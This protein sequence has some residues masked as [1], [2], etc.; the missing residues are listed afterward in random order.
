MVFSAVQNLE[1]RLELLESKLGDARKDESGA[2][3]KVK[4][5]STRLSK[6]PSQMPTAKGF[7]NLAKSTSRIGLY[8]D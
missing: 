4:R 7:G 8:S 5:F 1:R 2:H 3:E 6:V